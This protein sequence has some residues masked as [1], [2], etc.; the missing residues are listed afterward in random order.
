MRGPAAP[1][2]GSLR[3]PSL[4]VRLLAVLALGNLV[5]Q[6][7][8][9]FG[10]WINSDWASSYLVAGR[11]VS[12]GGHCLY[13]LDVQ[14]RQQQQLL[15]V[16]I[17]PGTEGGGFT[18][19][20]LA[21]WLI[22]PLAALEPHLSYLI[23]LGALVASMV[24]GAALLWRLLADV[25]RRW[26]APLVLLAMGTLP[27]AQAMATA[28]W[29]PLLLVA[30]AAGA[31][32]LASGRDFASGLS[33]SLLWVK[34]QLVWL[35][36]PLMVAARV[37]RLAA[38]LLAGGAVW[39]L[40]FPLLV[41]VEGAREWLTA[42]LPRHL[43]EARATIGLPALAGELGGGGRAVFVVAAGLLLAVLAG[44]WFWRRHL[45][46]DPLLALAAGLT[47]SILCSPHI[48]PSDALLLAVPLT[49]MAA[50]RPLAAV[51]L[52]AVLS[53]AYLADVTLPNGLAHVEALAVGALAVQLV[54]W[55]RAV[56]GAAPVPAA[57]G[58]PAPT[59]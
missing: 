39:A 7:V 26:R 54:R 44:C 56:P 14:Q 36:V 19:P 22:Q 38:G 43:A 57:S 17:V 18:N 4:A 45:R 59:G 49:V 42:L 47:L 37:P 21:A 2:L 6:T 30:C 16:A 40:T 1:A 28:G 34:P 48:W 29:D 31:L 50:R 46:A 20:P 53:A 13:C 33:L 55:L 3:R 12:A 5:A 27:A 51:R 25:P 58:D 10:D 8:R 9:S 11:M 35:V 32:L 52:S 15:H 41:G 23:F 24:A